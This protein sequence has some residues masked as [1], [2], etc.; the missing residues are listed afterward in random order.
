MDQDLPAQGDTGSSTT[1][2]GLSASLHLPLSPLLD[3]QQ[4]DLQHFQLL[5]SEK[6]RTSRKGFREAS[7]W[8]SWFI[9]EPI[10]ESRAANVKY[11]Y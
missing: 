5:V 7:D 4:D 10:I 1:S 8:L 2:S 11:F 6:N 3:K 9:R